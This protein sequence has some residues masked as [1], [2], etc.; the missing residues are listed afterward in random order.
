M[1]RV[2]DIINNLMSSKNMTQVELAIKSN[3][4]E[5]TISRYLN[6]THPIERNKTVIILC[7]MADALD[8]SLDELLGRPERIKGLNPNEQTLLNCFK[9]AT[10]KE[11]K[12]ILAI[13][14]EY[15]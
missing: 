3:T 6:N 4:T 10:P 5:A 9:K 8:V 11:Q 2:S 1:K 13:L 12:S 15:K 14:D 7:D